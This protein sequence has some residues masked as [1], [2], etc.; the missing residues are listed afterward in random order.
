MTMA[1]GELGNPRALQGESLFASAALQLFS[2]HG[3]SSRCSSQGELTW[4]GSYCTFVPIVYKGQRARL[5]LPIKTSCVPRYP[6]Q[7]SIHES[8]K[9]SIGLTEPILGVHHRPISIFSAISSLPRFSQN[10]GS[11]YRPSRPNNETGLISELR[12]QS[13]E[14]MFPLGSVHTANAGD[15]APVPL[16]P[17]PQFHSLLWTLFLYP[18]A[19]IA[20]PSASALP[21]FL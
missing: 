2:R 6:S 10:L 5:P 14:G 19:T 16:F 1:G 12:D 9:R 18:S 3:R 11:P 20:P 17:F 7:L 15:V 13:F 8:N 4:M 21:G